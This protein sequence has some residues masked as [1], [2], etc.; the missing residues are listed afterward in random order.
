MP[1]SNTDFFV[2]SN[3]IKNLAGLNW[4]VP[5]TC[6]AEGVCDTCEIMWAADN[7]NVELLAVGAEPGRPA[8]PSIILT[9]DQVGEL[10]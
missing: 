5:V 1:W 2:Q 9:V 8:I 6:V 4:F 10:P 3:S 7:G